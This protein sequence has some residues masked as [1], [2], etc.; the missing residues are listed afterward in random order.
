MDENGIYEAESKQAHRAERGVCWMPEAPAPSQNQSIVNVSVP[1]G[2]LVEAGSGYDVQPN[3]MQS[4][5]TKTMSARDG[6]AARPYVEFVTV[7]D[8]NSNIPAST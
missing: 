3:A 4:K 1:M 5:S 7:T 8:V 2:A 6:T